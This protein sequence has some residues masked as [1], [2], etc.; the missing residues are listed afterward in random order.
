MQIPVGHRL[1]AALKRHHHGYLNRRLERP[2][3]DGVDQPRARQLNDPPAAEQ[4]LRRVV[5]IV[6]F[7]AEKLT[8]A[9]RR[10][11][12]VVR[13]EEHTSELQSLMRSSYAVFCLKT[14]KILNNHIREP[15][16]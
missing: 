8:V 15:F 11:A 1:Q 7:E 10:H 9:V 16:T 13:S 4:R 5:E 2:A 3:P 6:G 12:V 14:Q